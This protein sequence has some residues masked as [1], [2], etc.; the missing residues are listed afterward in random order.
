M[1]PISQA[2]AMLGRSPWTL[3]RWYRLGLLPAVI[4]LGRWY[5]PMSFIASVLSSPQPKKAGVLED[6][7]EAWFAAHPASTGVSA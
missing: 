1:I 6:V 5:V 4:M 3:K 2:A 7:A